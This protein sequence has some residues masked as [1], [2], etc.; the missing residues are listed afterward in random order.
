[1]ANN[2][3][4]LAKSGLNFFGRMSA[5]AT[6]EIKNTLAI[7]NENSGL[8]EDLSMMAQKGAS[9]PFDRI[10]DI[11]QRVTKQ[12][13]RANLVLNKLNRFSHSVDRE[14]ET[15][16]L[17]KTVDVVLNLASRLI[18]MQGITIKVRAPSSP[19]L[20]NT[21][22]FYLENIIWRAIETICNAS[23]KAK[24]VNISLKNSSGTALL[25][26]SSD[27]LDS[28][29]MDNVFGSKEDLALL[30]HLKLS[31]KKNIENNGFDL[32]WPK[33]I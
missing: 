15:A 1:M 28:N 26:F 33:S 5:S 13:Q 8:M 31:I 6:H 29:L 20:I 22:L 14:T 25:G 9:L 17:E 16:N 12:V 7:I 27:S 2:D 3:N 24:Q 18:E 30:E 10:T 4:L 32:I 19:I 21:N 11:S 23:Q